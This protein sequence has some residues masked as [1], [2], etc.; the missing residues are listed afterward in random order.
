M[1]EISV[2]KIGWILL[3]V[4]NICKNV[5]VEKNDLVEKNEKIV[6]KTLKR[7]NIKKLIN[8]SLVKNL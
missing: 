4:E 6:I 7:K 1:N 5:T 8:Y 3:G 2:G